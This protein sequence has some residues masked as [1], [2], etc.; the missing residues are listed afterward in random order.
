ME[1]AA[2]GCRWRVAGVV[3][4]WGRCDGCAWVGWGNSAFVATKYQQPHISDRTHVEGWRL[5]V[6]RKRLATICGGHSSGPAAG[7]HG[8]GSLGAQSGRCLRAR[9]RLQ[10]RRKG[11]R[12][13]CPPCTTD[14]G[15]EVDTLPFPHQASGESDQRS[16]RRHTRPICM[17][18]IS[19]SSHRP[20]RALE[21]HSL[22]T[23]GAAQHEDAPGSRRECVGARRQER[24]RRTVIKD[25]TIRRE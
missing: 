7:E 1:V 12:L 6:V 18:A 11:S 2:G 5:P 24:S 16:S 19:S 8:H 17:H 3:R 10:G 15:A 23:A 14:F 4:G 13:L 25:S 21:R 22:H 9:L 20:D